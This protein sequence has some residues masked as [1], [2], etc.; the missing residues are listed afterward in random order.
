MPVIL[1]L[2]ADP[3]T[4]MKKH[5]R[6]IGKFLQAPETMRDRLNTSATM[7]ES[8]LTSLTIKRPLVVCICFRNP[9]TLSWRIRLTRDIGI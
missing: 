2:S 8:S 9:E 7:E 6:L 3:M 4:D 1:R 5:F